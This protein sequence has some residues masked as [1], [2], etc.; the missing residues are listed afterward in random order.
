MLDY[1]KLPGPKPAFAETSAVPERMVGNTYK[2]RGDTYGR[3]PS[4]EW[5]VYRPLASPEGNLPVREGRRFTAANLPLA[6]Q[7]GR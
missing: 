7:H 2:A 4:Y 5:R 6:F 1:A 3:R